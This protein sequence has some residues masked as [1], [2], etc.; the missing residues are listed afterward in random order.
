MGD[1]SDADPLGRVVG[2]HPS[3]PHLTSGRSSGPD[4]L[5]LLGEESID[6]IE[7]RIHPDDRQRFKNS[8]S[9]I[10]AA[11]TYWFHDYRVVRPDGSMIYVEDR[12]EVE[13]NEEGKIIEIFGTVMDVTNRVESN[14]K[15]KA[16]MAEIEQLRDRLQDENL[17][18][19]QQVRSAERHRRLIG[20]N[21]QFTSALVAAERVAPT[22]VTVL[23]L[24]E[25]GTGKELIAREIH[26]QSERNERPLVSVNCAA[27]SSELI[28]S[29]LFG[30]EA[31]A[32]TGA[33]KKRK[34][35]FEL[36]DGGTLFLDEIGDLPAD[37]QAKILRAL[38]T[39]EFERLGSMETLTVD[40]RLIT[41]TNRD[42]KSMVRDGEFRADLYYR[43]NS[44]PI[45][46]PPLRERREDIPLLANHFVEKH[47]PML[48]KRV[49]YISPDMIRRMQAMDWPGNVREMEGFMQR[50]LI[51]TTG[52][53]LD[54]RDESDPAAAIAVQDLD[55]IQQE[56][57]VSVLDRCNW[58]VGGDKGAATLLGVPPSTLRSRMKKLGIQR[59]H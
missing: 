8:V 15:L 2:A 57:I 1:A 45:L 50:A 25:T 22:D 9:E 17:Y 32:F 55:T 20:E 34:G 39:G 44:F 41:A 4:L 12:W 56:H 24:G 59:P 51:A 43:I 42:L 36:A 40:V 29:E 46:V 31:G 14:L 30:H 37:V 49:N 26:E 19:K 10:G 35:R 13:R 52:P 54:Y 47:A 5:L 27:L 7:S 21:P 28:E 18:L 16:A 11:D 58:V 48:G 33:D 53:E 3:T 6:E 38:Q 23:I